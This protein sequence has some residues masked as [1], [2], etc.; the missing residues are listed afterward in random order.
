MVVFA[1][2]AALPPQRGAFDHRIPLQPGVKPINIQP[3]RHSSLKKYIIEKLV[4]EMLQQGV[5][6]YNNSPFSSLVVVVEK[7]DGSCL[8]LV[9]HVLHL[10]QV[11]EVMVQ[12]KLL[13]KRSKYVFGVPSV[14][15]LG[16]L[17]SAQGVS[18]DPNKIVANDSANQAFTELK[19]ALTFALVFVLPNYSLPFIV[20]TDASGAVLMQSDH[21]IA[22]ISKGLTPMHIALSIYERELL[23][24][25]TSQK[26]ITWINQQLRR[27]GKL[28]VGNNAT[29]R[30]KI[31]TLW[32]SSPCIVCQRN[33][34][35]TAASPGLLQP[36]PIPAL[37]WIDITM[38]FI[39]GLP[40]SKTSTAYYSQTDGQSEVLNCCL[41][42]YLRCFCTDSHADWSLFLSLSEWWYNTSP[43]SAIQTS[44]F[45]LLYGYPPPLHLPYLLRD[46]DSLS[47]DKVALLREF[48]VQ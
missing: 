14:E 12:H 11:F 7:K 9:D 1:E 26:H 47:I 36:L 42:T 10:Q 21:L 20:E 22:F 5:I 8:T 32:H 16:H 3:Y 45:E 35:D 4:K 38:E 34:Y 44:P 24:L 23:A 41:E 31:L 2:P 18:T 48:K 25:H 27:K 13:S 19:K 6:Q 39:E 29:L 33:K 43:H 17:I 28:L 46:S 37:P 40:K 15:Y 30:T